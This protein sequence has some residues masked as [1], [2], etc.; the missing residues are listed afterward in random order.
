MEN[1][2]L[3]RYPSHVASETSMQSL[4]SDDSMRSD[5]LDLSVVE[6]AEGGKQSRDADRLGAASYPWQQLE[7]LTMGLW[8]PNKLW[9]DQIVPGV[10][11]VNRRFERILAP[12]WFRNNRSW[13]PKSI[14]SLLFERQVTN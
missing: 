7:S 8:R 5:V 4:E 3:Q 11:A 1:E 12:L 10:A 14:R 9:E 6:R 13:N 2:L